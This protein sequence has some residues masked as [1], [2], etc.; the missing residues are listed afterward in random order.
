[1]VVSC[2]SNRVTTLALSR[3][4]GRLFTNFTFYLN[5]FMM[6]LTRVLTVFTA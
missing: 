5:I 6:L 2:Y 3:L 4:G 1:M